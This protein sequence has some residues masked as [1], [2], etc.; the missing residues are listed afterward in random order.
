L[1]GLVDDEVAVV[2]GL[3]AE[4]VELEVGGGVEGGGELVEVVL[5][6]ARVEA[7]DLDATVEVAA[8]GAAGGSAQGA[9]AVANDVPAEDLLVDVGELDAAGELGEVGVLLDQG[10]GI[11]DDG[12]LEVFQR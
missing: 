11:E 10:L 2:D 9:D 3:D 12:L 6:E 8:E 5:E 7:L 4:E 1:I